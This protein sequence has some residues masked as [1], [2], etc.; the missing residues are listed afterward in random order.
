MVARNPGWMTYRGG[1]LGIPSEGQRVLE[2]GILIPRVEDGL[3]Q[4]LW[5]EMSDL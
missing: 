4:E 5:S 3:M 2:T 1:L